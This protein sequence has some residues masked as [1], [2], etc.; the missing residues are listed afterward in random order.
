MLFSSL[1]LNSVPWASTSLKTT[2]LVV[3]MYLATRLV[4]ASSISSSRSLDNS[5]LRLLKLRCRNVPWTS[6]TKCVARSPP[7]TSSMLH[8]LT[9]LRCLTLSL[10][11]DPSPEQ[12][13]TACAT[14]DLASSTPSRVSFVSVLGFRSSFASIGTFFR[15]LGRKG[16]PGHC[17]STLSA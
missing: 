11:H 14:L 2:S 5:V 8:S 15:L 13:K 10:F 3:L 7:S 16:G 4:E 17:V 12:N 9:R 6:L 1:C